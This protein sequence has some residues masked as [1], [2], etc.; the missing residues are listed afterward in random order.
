[1]TVI[2]IAQAFFFLTSLKT[3]SNYSSYRC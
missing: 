1:M 3:M 2:A